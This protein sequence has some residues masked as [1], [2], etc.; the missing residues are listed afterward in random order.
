MHEKH[1]I[2][3]ML[4]IVFIRIFLIAVRVSLSVCGGFGILT[5]IP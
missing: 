3:P 1:R 2:A 4:F 5:V